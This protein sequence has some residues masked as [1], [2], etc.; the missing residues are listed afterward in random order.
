MTQL[1]S[2]STEDPESQAKADFDSG[3]K[4]ETKVKPQ[5]KALFVLAPY[6]LRYKARIIGALVAVAAAVAATLAVPFAIRR[7]ID[8]GFAGDS[9][10][11]IDSY[12]F[13]LVGVAALLALASGMRFYFVTTLGER[14]A[15]DLR[16]DV[17]AHLVRLDA[18]FFDKAR[19]GE[20]LSRLTA[21]TTQ[22]KSAFGATAALAL[23]NF[24]LFVGA[25]LLM[26][27]SSPKLSAY[28]LVA[29]PVIVLPLV[30][31]GR[32]VR[33]RSR[34]AQ[35]TLAEA[36]AYAGENLAA[37]R[38]MQAFGAEPATV[39][40]F[41]S[42]VEA[43]YVAARN[44]ATA[45]AILTI[46]VIF[47]VFASV[48]CVLWFGAQ[49]V[50]AGRMTGGQLSQFVLFALLGAGA[51]GELS[52]VWSEV[53]AAA[54]AAGRIGEILAVRPEIIAPPRPLAL[55]VPCRGEIRFE[56][57]SFSYPS[58]PEDAALH[59]VSFTVRPG[60]RVA[61]V[62]P[63]G[64][65]KSTLFQLLLRF[66]DPT[67]GRI[68]L[69]GVDIAAVDPAALRRQIRTVPQDPVI[70]HMSIAENIRYGLPEASDARVREAASRAAADSFIRA[71]PEGYE[72]TAGERGATLSGGERQRLAIARAILDDAPILLLDEATSALDSESESLVQ[73]ALAELTAQRTTLVIAH[74][75]A[76]VLAA[77]RILVFDD[78]RLVEE[79]T[80]ASLVA[81][82]ALYARLAKLQFEQAATEQKPGESA[83]AE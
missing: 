14:I 40:H 36:S 32:W 20:L 43:A 67:A 33:K 60:E 41:S 47:L 53:L 45:R 46:V 68:L 34:S 35:D 37:V 83:A 3:S 42:A 81:K 54:G 48:V 75:L 71:L 73:G 11:L 51:L 24:F 22:M 39:R 26:V 2:A 57:A 69:D 80:H 17:F 78:G 72:T 82:N 31:S 7:M 62:G 1:A 12:F 74:R 59:D 13:A 30:A 19:V 79:G 76:T 77:D 5:P 55:P 23:R 15:A 49:D 63:S 70:F 65:G 44:A 58:R 28:V 18:A 6:L 16:S 61:I 50:L 4:P 38:V 10:G 8:F 21:D 64:A 9:A 27:Y 25:T 29:I 52:G 66:Y 56:A